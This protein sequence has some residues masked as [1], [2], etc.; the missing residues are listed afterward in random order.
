ML[1]DAGSGRGRR[2]RGDVLL[3]LHRNL[4]GLLGVPR[5]RG[6]GLLLAAH[7]GADELTLR[8]AGLAGLGH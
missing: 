2:L 1:R 3:P 5:H 7:V 6:G 4:P 8:P